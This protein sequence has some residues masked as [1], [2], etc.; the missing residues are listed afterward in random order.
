MLGSNLSSKSIEKT[1]S[2][3]LGADRHHFGPE[4]APRK[5]A[6]TGD[7]PGGR[8]RKKNLLAWPLTVSRSGLESRTRDS[9]MDFLYG[10]SCDF[11]GG[12]VGSPLC[13]PVLFLKHHIQSL[14]GFGHAG[15]QN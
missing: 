5:Q 3:D 14:S 7:G 12:N 9:D 10:L 1:D 6:P 11:I 4:T 2:G 13:D 8:R 15:E